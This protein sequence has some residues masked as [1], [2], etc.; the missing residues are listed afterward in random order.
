MKDSTSQNGDVR[1]V[2]AQDIVSNT[3]LY[4][5]KTVSNTPLYKGKA[6][7]N[8]PLYK[9]KTVSNCRQSRWRDTSVTTA[10]GLWERGEQRRAHN[11]GRDRNVC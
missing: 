7:S 9:G 11:V 6:V 1:P 3:P 8:T 2:S 10:T 4:K 5:G